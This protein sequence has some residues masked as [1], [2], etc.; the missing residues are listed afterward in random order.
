M[1]TQR[2]IDEYYFIY[3]HKEG[4]IAMC[5]YTRKGLCA[6]KCALARLS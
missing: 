1:R 3:S 2:D 6:Q 4:Q 5:T